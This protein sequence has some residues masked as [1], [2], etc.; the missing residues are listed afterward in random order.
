MQLSV[1]DLV[2]V[3]TGQSHTQALAAAV[4]LARV[5][6]RTGFRRYWTAEHHNFSA[7][8]ATVP[9]LILM[10]V[11][12]GTER[13]RLGSG[14]VML[15]N[16]TALDVAEQFTL[17]DAAFPGRVDLGLGR[18]PGTDPFTAYALRGGRGNEA[19]EAFPEQVMDIVRLFG[20]D[21]LELSLGARRHVL[22]PGPGGAVPVPVWLLGSSGYSAQLAGSLGLRYVFAHHFSGAGTATALQL[23]RDAFQPRPDAGRLGTPEA[24]EAF[25]SANVVVAETQQEAEELAEPHALAMALLRSN[26]PMQAG[27]LVGADVRS[28]ITPELRDL[29]SHLTDPW[30]VGTPAQAAE[31][32][33]ALAAEHGVEE[34]MVHPVAGGRESD[35]LDAYPARERTLELLA[36][37]LGLP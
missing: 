30:I 7:V 10:H 36:A 29:M 28:R 34:I 11:G 24:P 27:A 18:A 2:P 9:S 6:D 12:Q 15:P 8:G 14:G 21:G 25:I 22:R 35:P 33:T 13:I 37:E 31:R 26:T 32:L 20:E 1:L 3:R 5:A 17:L 16:S 4:R 23:Y 19:V